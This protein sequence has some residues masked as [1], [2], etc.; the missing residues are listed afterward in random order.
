M[1]G[2]QEKM[3]DCTLVE[4]AG[5]D[6]DLVGAGAIPSLAVGVNVNTPV[7]TPVQI[8]VGVL[9]A[10]QVNTAVFSI[11]YQGGGQ[12]LSYTGLNSVK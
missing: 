2:K 11:A 5:E 9:T 7:F 6:L 4:L 12:Y 10:T 3:E 1:K 8:N